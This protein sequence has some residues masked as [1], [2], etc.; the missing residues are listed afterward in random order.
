LTSRRSRGDGGLHWDE[1]RQRW[2]ATVTL[3]YTPA[4]KR[5]VR[6]GSGKSKTEAKKKLNQLLRDYE[7]GLAVASGAYTVEQAV[8]DWLA[9]GL[10]GKAAGTISKNTFFAE[11]HVIPA[12]GS[13]KLRDLSAEDV[14]K[15]LTEKAAVLSTSTLLSVR[16]ILRR[17][18]S[19]AQARDKVKRNVVLL[20]DAPK[21]QEGRPSKA[22][23]LAAAEPL[24]RAAEAD[25]S[26]VGMYIVV[27][28]L[29]GAR[30]EELRALTWS[31]VDLIGDTAATPPI[32]PHVM[33][34]RSVRV[35]GDTK[36]R[37]SWRTLALP[38]RCVGGLCSHRERQAAV[39]AAAGA[40]WRGH[41]LVFASEVGTEL[42]AANVRRG[43]R[44]IAQRAGL[45]PVLKA[46][47]AGSRG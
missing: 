22:L 33:V 41:D 45:G 11:F 25:T 29:I 15:W 40:R 19:R 24:L 26:S 3:G 21:G 18:V 10:N 2:I 8:R 6:K 4:G 9:F 28:L 17:A 44:R 36:T 38:G 12:L 43:F 20:C 32:P 1:G 5:I 14:D 46:T 34:W 23:T 42:D 47:F 7:D 13:R 30:T 31:H 39:R 35:G 16:S 37:K 27:S